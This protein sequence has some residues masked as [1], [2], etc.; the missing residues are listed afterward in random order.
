MLIEE[1]S[2][3]SLETQGGWGGG[4]K[5]DHMRAGA[6]HGGETGGASV[7]W[8]GGWEVGVGE[9]AEDEQPVEER[10]G[11]WAEGEEK[12]APLEPTEQ[13]IGVSELGALPHQN[14]HPEGGEGRAEGGGLT[15]RDRLSQGGS[16]AS[17]LREEGRVPRY[18]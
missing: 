5:Q 6:A 2:C 12:G 11:L 3:V 1:D 7:G 18:V 14:L 10:A 8:E 16:P 13:R 17:S 9:A 15:R 4:L